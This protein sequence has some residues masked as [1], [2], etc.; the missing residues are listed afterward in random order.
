MTCHVIFSIEEIFALDILNQSH[1]RCNETEVSITKE[2]V[3]FV[4]AQTH[5]VNTII[6]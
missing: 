4:V 3:V 1:I 6:F 5:K 2:K